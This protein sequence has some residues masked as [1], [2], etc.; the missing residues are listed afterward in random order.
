[1]YE[2]LQLD[3]NM[4]WG[5]HD[6]RR[7]DEAL[8]KVVEAFDEQERGLFEAKALREAASWRTYNLHKA[9]RH[10]S[11]T[12]KNKQ[13]APDGTSSGEGTSSGKD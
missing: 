7:I 3:L 5:D 2:S 8:D 9:R 10:R 6:V 12:E 4:T 1:M 13:E 11:H